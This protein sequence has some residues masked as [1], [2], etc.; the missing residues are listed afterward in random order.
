MRFFYSSGAMGYG[1]GW[2]WHRFYH[3][4][5]LPV[6]TKTITLRPRKGYPF[7]I[8]RIGNTIYNHFALDNMGVLEWIKQNPDTSV[9]VSIS[10]ED[11]EIEQMIYVIE[12]SLLPV[13]GIE[14]NYSCPNVEH[15]RSKRIVPNSVLPLYLKLN[16]QQDPYDFDLDN[17]CG[18]RVNAVSCWFGGMSGKAA[19]KF[20][21]P[22]IRKF[23]TEGLNVAGC[24]FL[25]L[26]DIR[27]L[28]EYCGCKEIGIGST[29]LIKPKLIES[30]I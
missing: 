5:K 11:H 28:E 16:S 15:P 27:Y 26:D 25:C 14:L 21:W 2:W 23:N 30:L 7:A 1:N 18:I 17:I 10:G 24:S 9:V 29:I 12:E 20:N 6:V 13:T 3:F 4:P 19:Q 8:I 22:F